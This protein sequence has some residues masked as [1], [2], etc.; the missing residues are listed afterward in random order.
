M[1]PRF[2]TSATSFRLWLDRNHARRT[3]LLVG[4][5]K[6]GAARVGMSYAEAL[7]EALAF[8]WIDGVRKSLNADSYTI[9]FS[10]RKS[11]SVWSLVN[12][13]HAKRLIAAGRME[14]A[15]MRAFETREARRSGIYTYETAPA[16]F[17]RAMASALAADARAKEFFDAQPPG[18]RRT[19]TNWIMS[20]KKEETRMR[21]VA[22]LITKSAQHQRID[23]LKPRS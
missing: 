15:G 10:P 6:K 4:F 8:G 13:R 3:E 17:D 9:R 7:D 22:L 20:G 1:K 16:T 18:Y 21:R 11:R 14:A 2:F 12:I 23:F 5:H 19:T